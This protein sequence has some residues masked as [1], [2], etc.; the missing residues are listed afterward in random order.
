MFGIDDA[1]AAGLK[2]LDKVIPDPQ[3]KQAAQ[4][5]MLKMQ[6]E[7]AFKDIEASLQEAQMQADVNKAEAASNSIF[8]AGWRSF[9][10]WVCGGAFAWHYVGAPL[11]VWV[12]SMSGHPTPMPEIQ[13]GDLFTLMLGMLG[14]G[15]MRTYEKTNGVAAGH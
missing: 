11:F 2:I 3:A 15:G 5:E 7:G 1:I 9:I 6:Q 4:L 13:L 14:L 12:A 8:V 10:G